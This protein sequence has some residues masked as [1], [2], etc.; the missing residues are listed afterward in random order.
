MEMI[1]KKTKIPIGNDMKTMALNPIIKD[2]K[3]IINNA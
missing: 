2:A 1:N 3:D